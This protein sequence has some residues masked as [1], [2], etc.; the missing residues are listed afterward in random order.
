MTTACG[1]LRAGLPPLGPLGARIWHVAEAFPG[2]A[3]EDVTDGNSRTSCES[4]FPAAKGW[5]PNT[6]W[7]RPV[8]KGLLEHFASDAHIARGTASDDEGKKPAV[9]TPCR[10]PTTPVDADADPCA[11]HRYETPSLALIFTLAFILTPIPTLTA[12][13]CDTDPCP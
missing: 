3:F 6:G 7:G 12:A 10:P 2:A 4:G 13:R 9:V 11:G 1:C 8:W 5:D